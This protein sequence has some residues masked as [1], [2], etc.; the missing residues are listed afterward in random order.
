MTVHP[1]F[2]EGATALVTGA[3]S[4]IGLA[5][6]KR[7]AEL[8]LRVCLVDADEAAVE[9]VGRGAFSEIVPVQSGPLWPAPWTCQTDR[10]WR[11]CGQR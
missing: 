8:G 6:A 10:P 2:N 11:P 9:T 3:A 4:G 1:A 7:F 5:A